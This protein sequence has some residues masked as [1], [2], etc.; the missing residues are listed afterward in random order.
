MEIIFGE[1]RNFIKNAS[2]KNVIPNID[3]DITNQK[4]IFLKPFEFMN[5]THKKL[6]ILEES[7]KFVQPNSIFLGKRTEIR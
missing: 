2:S 3:S 1:T 7:G 6:I 5:T 4:Y